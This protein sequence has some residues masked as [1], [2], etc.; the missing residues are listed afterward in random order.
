MIEDRAAWS[1][2]GLD[3]EG[4][5]RE[6]MKA[7][8]Q[9]E[10][11][12]RKGAVSDLVA[13]AEIAVARE[14]DLAVYRPGDW[15]VPN[16][17]RT[18]RALLAGNAW[19][20]GWDGRVVEPV[21]DRGLARPERV[22]PRHCTEFAYRTLEGAVEETAGCFR[23]FT[24]VVRCFPDFDA[25]TSS[26][27]EF[28]RRILTSLQEVH[29][30]GYVIDDDGVEAV[31][32][33][34]KTLEELTAS[35]GYQDAGLGE[36]PPG[37]VGQLVWEADL[38]SPGFDGDI[39]FQPGGFQGRPHLQCL[40]LEVLGEPRRR[41]LRTARGRLQGSSLALVP[42]P[43]PD[44]VEGLA[45]DAVLEAE[46]GDQPAWGVIGPLSDRKADTG[47]DRLI[48]LHRSFFTPL[49]PSQSARSAS[50]SV[51]TKARRC[52][53]D[54]LRQNCHRCPAT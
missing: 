30:G 24:A 31:L 7:M 13:A 32:E 28:Q 49:R 21:V 35:L 1:A 23:H 10:S 41:G 48:L 51:T 54:V 20:V 2:H 42:R 47:I 52:V 33:L 44:R 4:V 8:K 25:L 26:L 14:D 38:S 16:L 18:A 53:T 9:V 39:D 5:P 3:T 37:V 12:A 11:L 43:G 40:L 27:S 22:R 29:P 50:G 34:V 19:I 36:M 46:R 17:C 45:G 6:L 15:M